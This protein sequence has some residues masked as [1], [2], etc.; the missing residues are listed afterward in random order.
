MEANFKFIPLNFSWV[1]LHPK[2]V[3]VVQVVGGAFFGTFPTIFYRYL[4]K[5]L[6]DQ[7]YT[8][9][10]I[11]YRFTF[12]H[13][14]VAIGLI[15]DLV[16]LRPM[17]VEAAKRRGYEYQIYQE[18]PTEEKGNYYWLGHSLGSKYIALLELLSD[19][20]IKDS[21]SINM[22]EVL[23][24]CVGKDQKD[25]I[26]R[27]LEGV[28]LDEIS[29]K[30][31]ATLLLAPAITGIESAIPIKAVADLVKKLGLDVNP[32]VE[33]THCL[34]LKSRLFNLF[35]LIAFA[36][37]NIAKDTVNW[38][39]G[40]LSGRLIQCIDLPDRGHLAPL[41]WRNGDSLLAKTVIDCLA[42]FKEK[43]DQISQGKAI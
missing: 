22:E 23:G 26:L 5:Q 1:A 8:V 10:A 19:L 12:R 3:G 25:E 39:K 33:Q 11:P 16:D 2:P 41:G 17:M 14:S 35:S 29:L 28:D 13:W 42:T 15:R 7:G 9:I 40:N 30:N 4:I 34:I 38:I 24:N 36:K 32:T 37:D 18:K 27:S 20:E 43:C 31:Q 21:K 6:F